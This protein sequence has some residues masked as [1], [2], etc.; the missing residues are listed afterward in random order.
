M[1]RSQSLSSRKY[2]G[3]DDRIKSKIK[4]SEVGAGGNMCV[5]VKREWSRSRS[6]SGG[7]TT[8]KDD[9]KEEKEIKQG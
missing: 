1:N 3:S 7:K 2:P 9:G 4:T 6:R 5:G 8:E